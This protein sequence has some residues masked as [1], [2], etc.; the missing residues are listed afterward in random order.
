[1]VRRKTTQKPN[2]D[3]AAQAHQEQSMHADD[4]TE[5]QDLSVDA[6]IRSS[7]DSN[8]SVTNNDG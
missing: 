4:N 6:A 1:M 8:L 7:I 3:D 2:E 5:M